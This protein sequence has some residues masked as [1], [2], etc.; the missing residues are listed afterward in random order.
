MMEKRSYVKKFDQLEAH[1][2]SLLETLSCVE[3]EKDAAE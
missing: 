2:N 1:N 3:N